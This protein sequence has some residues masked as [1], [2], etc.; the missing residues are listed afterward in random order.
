MEAATA[1]LLENGVKVGADSWQQ[2]AKN[3]T[4]HC[5]FGEAG[6]CCRICATARPGD[7]P[8]RSAA[9]NSLAIFLI[10]AEML[11]EKVI[12]KKK[13][14]GRGEGMGAAG[15]DRAGRRFYL[16][17]IRRGEDSGRS[18]RLGV[19]YRITVMWKQGDLTSYFTMQRSAA[20]RS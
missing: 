9:A 20:R 7:R 19:I 12:G 14:S 16:C 18:H 8:S 10:I 11:V 2:R 3:Q 17:I 13:V 6:T 15:R 1:M 5:G 4:P